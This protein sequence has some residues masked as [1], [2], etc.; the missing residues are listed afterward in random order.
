MAK[1]RPR[2]KKLRPRNADGSLK[3]IATPNENRKQIMATALKTRLKYAKPSHAKRI[4]SATLFGML[5]LEGYLTPQQYEA[6][7]RYMN[8]INKYR[9]TQGFGS[10]HIRAVALGAT[11]GMSQEYEDSPEYIEKIKS[12]YMNAMGLTMSIIHKVSIDGYFQT[13]K[14]IICEQVMLAASWPQYTS[15]YEIKNICERL[16]RLIDFYK[17]RAK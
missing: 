2:S 6:S 12:Q 4:E 5:M 10:E 1:G 7:Q 9:K 3:K 8:T 16:D 15:Q 11:P 14:E 13:F 17:I